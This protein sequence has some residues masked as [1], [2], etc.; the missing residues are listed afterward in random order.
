MTDIRQQV[1]RSSLGTKQARAARRTV[2]TAAASKVVARAANMPRPA[3]AKK[4]GG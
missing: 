1:E 3:R 2:S 4:S